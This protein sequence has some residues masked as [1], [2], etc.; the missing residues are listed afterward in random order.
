MAG[1]SAYSNFDTRFDA[2]KMKKM[3]FTT[4]WQ[5]SFDFPYM[6]M[7]IPPVGDQEKWI[8][9]G[10]D[11]TS[12]AGMR[13]YARTMKKMGF[14]VLN[15]FNVTEFGTKMNRP[16]PPLKTKDDKEIWKDPND[17]FYY[18]LPESWLPVPDRVLK[19]S[20]YFHRQTMPGGSHMTWEGGIVTDPGEP[21]Y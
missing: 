7:F 5:A 3:D 19:D 10:G 20:V 16:V 2:V 1:T 17:F 6:G 14:Y 21:V 4:N 18:K 9:F 8:R 13:E 12:I 11:T 15:Y